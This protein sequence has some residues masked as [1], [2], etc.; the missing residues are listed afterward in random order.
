MPDAV[1]GAPALHA[2]LIA[3]AAWRGIGELY[4]SDGLTHSAAIAYYSLLSLFPFFLL[5]LSIVG[6]VTANPEERD[7]VEDLGL[8]QVERHDQRVLGTGVARG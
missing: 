8:A 4:N 7:E 1:T 2:R 3:R 5:V 6:S